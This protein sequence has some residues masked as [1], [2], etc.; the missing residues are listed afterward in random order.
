[1]SDE[2]PQRPILRMPIKNFKFVADLTEQD[3][4]WWHTFG[5]KLD[6]AR[7]DFRKIPCWWA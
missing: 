5:R 3:S 4:A 6:E 2:K 1:M 7:K